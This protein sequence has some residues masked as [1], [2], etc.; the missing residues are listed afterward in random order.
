MN[1]R[2]WM[3]A[4]TLALAGCSTNNIKTTYDGTTGDAF[5]LVAADGL[6]RVPTDGARPW[7]PSRRMDQ[8]AAAT[9]D[10]PCRQACGGSQESRVL[11]PA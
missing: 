4:L 3:A 2:I 8:R 1:Y 9:R 11:K 10:R 7:P 5:V 6:G